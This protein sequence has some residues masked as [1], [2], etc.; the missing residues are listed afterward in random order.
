MSENQITQALLTPYCPAYSHG[1]EEFTVLASEGGVKCQKG[2][3]KEN[4]LA[5]WRKSHCK[6]K[7]ITVKI[8][9]VFLKKGHNFVV[10]FKA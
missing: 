9:L 8:L 7:V 1:Q 5:H 3:M 4:D 6:L 10:F 2:D